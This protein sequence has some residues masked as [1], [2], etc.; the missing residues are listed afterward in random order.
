M[1]FKKSF[2]ICL[3]LLVILS[4]GTAFADENA[5]DSQDAQESVSEEPAV[6]DVGSSSENQQDN[7]SQLIENEDYEVSISD[8]SYD[9]ISVVEVKNMPWDASG[10]ISIS[11]DGKEA[12]NQGVHVSGNALILNDL[13]LAFDNHDVL[14]SY[15][16]D[17]KYAGFSKNATVHPHFIVSCDE[18][19]YTWGTLTVDT[20]SNLPGYIKI[21][22]DNKVVY[23][24][25]ASSYVEIELDKYSIGTH[26][27]EVFYSEKSFKKGKFNRVSFNVYGDF[28]EGDMKYGDSARFSIA[29]PDNA[30]GFA[31]F[32]DKEY[33]F[34]FDKD[35]EGYVYDV[36][37]DISGF[38][39]GENIVEFH[40]MNQV[41][42]YPV[43][44][45]PKVVMPTGLWINGNHY[46]TFNASSGING[47]L[48]LSGFM[49]GAFKVDNGFARI[50]ISNLSLGNHSL[51]VKYE[52]Y[53][54]DYDVT[55]MNETPQVI[56]DCNFPSTVYAWDWIYNWED[57]LLYRLSLYAGQ[58]T[59][60][61]TTKIYDENGRMEVYEGDFYEIIW[62]P[63]WD[64]AGNHTITIMFEGDGNFEPFNKTIEYEVIDHDCYMD[65]GGVYVKLPGD[66]VGTLTVYVNGNNLKSVKLNGEGD[67]Y[68][69]TF[70][71]F[72]NMKKDED[73]V[74]DVV[75]SANNNKY[76]F[77]HTENFTLNCP[78]YIY[79]SDAIWG[80]ED[81]MGFALPRDIKN[82]PVIKIDDETYEYESYRDDD[83]YSFYV[84]ISGLKP[85]I[86]DVIVTYGGDAKYPSN[87]SNATFKVIAEIEGLEDSYHDYGSKFGVHL[88]LPDDAVGNLSVEISFGDE[89]DYRLFKTTPIKNGRAEIYLPSDRVGNYRFN[90]FFNGNYEVEN[91]HGVFDV[92]P[93]VSSV[94]TIKYGDKGN[95]SVSMDGMDDA[96]LA[97]CLYDEESDVNAPI[98]EFDLS[99]GNIVTIDKAIVDRAKSFMKIKWD[100]AVRWGEAPHMYLTTHIYKEDATFHYLSIIKVTFAS[101]ITGLANVNMLYSSGK[102]LTLKVY[103]IFGKPV[104]SGETVKIKIGKTTFSAKTKNGVVKFKIPNTITPGKYTITASYKDFKVSKKLTVKQILTLKTVK[105]KKSSKKLVLTT[106]LK[107]VNGKYIKGKTVTFKFNGKTY[108]AKTNKKGVAKYTI[109]KSVLK[110]LKVGKSIKY[111]AT[112]LK[113]TVKKTAKVKK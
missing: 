72:T 91:C 104:K 105:V 113:A 86:H 32:K 40:A 13:N 22:I 24:K 96:R 76:S 62:A 64:D 51:N 3:I 71:A 42:N 106:T 2:L 4:A 20:V 52:N 25:K 69:T 35:S 109:K 37:V 82:K 101:K 55:V 54:W 16:G 63:E 88:A 87:S 27:Y 15:S 59:V 11:I 57:I 98:A 5:T 65:N 14:I 66:A 7:H 107:K 33:P 36:Y 17:G 93:K 8:L 84:D 34:I 39:V 61:G 83:Y 44:V 58:Y 70:V 95:I 41:I 56:F 53:S 110:K 45:L 99:K 85:G 29:L 112:Y 103:D 18:N 1:K 26:N 28:E 73:Y 6:A 90:A 94:L 31:K 89:S 60:T 78:I 75:Y 9:Y 102:T 49:N 10:N 108:K 21:V 92:V 77:N 74:V 48:I 80:Q 19:V 97:I 67:V 46:L 50:P 100:D 111:Q 30:N 79:A 47:D 81:S 12:Y 43:F 38:D 68:E 23:N